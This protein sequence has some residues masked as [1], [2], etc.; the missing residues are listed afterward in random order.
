MRYQ[1]Y[2][3]HPNYHVVERRVGVQE[4]KDFYDISKKRRTI[5]EFSS[6]SV[7]KEII[8]NAIRAAGTAPS[9]ANLQPWYFAV[10]ESKK[11]KQ[12][13][14]Q[15]AE[16]EE[17]EFYQARAP[18]TWLVDLEPL[19]TDHVKAYLDEA[20]FLI[21]VFA[22]RKQEVNGVMKKT[23]YPVESTSLATG[24]L[25]SSLH[26]S[27]LAT[28]THT[29]KPIGFLNE[30]LGLE[31]HFKPQMLLVTGYPKLPVRVPKLKR[32]NLE[33]ISGVY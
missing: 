10:V 4:S 21:A 1:N 16:A 28:L 13:I 9:G 22:K 17:R 30:V 3:L 29:P 31:S 18:K 32:K 8:F 14:R 6:E 5:R 7:D 27:G 23:Y 11:I 24:I 15:A 12:K 20:P 25:I 33:E 19:E 2:E 26:R